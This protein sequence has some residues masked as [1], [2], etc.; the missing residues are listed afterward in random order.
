MNKAKSIVINNIE[1][2]MSEKKINQANLA[3][4]LNV[5]TGYVSMLLNGKR[6]FSAKVLL[7]LAEALQVD[8][9]DLT[10]NSLLDTEEYS[11]HLRGT[12]ESGAAKEA[13]I[14]WLMD[15]DDFVRISNLTKRK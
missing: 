8:S 1:K 2:I 5:S 12:A 11:I 3:D 9:E 7:K 15:M 6:N 14:D 10:K 4:L 13:I